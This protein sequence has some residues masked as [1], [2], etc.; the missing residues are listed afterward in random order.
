MG[1]RWARGTL[2]HRHTSCV[3]GALPFVASS[4]IGYM[5][6]WFCVF[7]HRQ[8]WRAVQLSATTHKSWVTNS[9]CISALMRFTCTDKKN[10]RS[11]VWTG[12]QDEHTIA[13]TWKLVHGQGK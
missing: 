2:G 13:P 10:R 3:I 4:S 8:K 9:K 6:S 1:G 12:I 11:K 7:W 5:S